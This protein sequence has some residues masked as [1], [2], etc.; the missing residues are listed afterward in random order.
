MTIHTLLVTGGAGFIGS[1]FIRHALREHPGWRIINLDKLT[2]AGNPENLRDIEGDSRYRFVRGDV[3][4]VALV[5]SIVPQADAIINFAAE[6]HV[7]RSLLDHLPFV[8]TNVYGTSVLLEAALRHKTR[9][10]HVSTDEVYG[11][12]PTGYSAHEGDPLRPRSPY[13]ASKA[14][15]DLLCLG[16]FISHEAPVVILRMT[17]NF[18]PYQYPEKA[19]PLFVTNAMEDKPLPVYGQGQQVRDWLY[20][21]DACAALDI[22][23][24]QGEIGQIYNVAGGNERPNIEVARAILHVVGKPDSLIT[25]VEDRKAH[26]QRYSLDCARV[27]GLGWKPCY[28]FEVA[29][30]KT[31]RWYAEHLRWW[32]RI[33]QGDFANYY[34]R[35]YARRF[36]KGSPR[37][38]GSSPSRRSP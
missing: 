12:I 3:C 35:Q 32:R 19:I 9:M 31:V 27:R 2:Y 37:T 21:E 7:D 6:T 34:A 22:V 26:D 38:E 29:L 33:K 11:E 10:L 16:L 24:Q 4:D 23:L 13:A 36:P 20:V 30:E 15:A 28:T 25:F 8:L 17:N 18:G 5:E 14:S 1:N